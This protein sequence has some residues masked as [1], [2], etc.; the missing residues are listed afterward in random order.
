MVWPLP[1]KMALYQVFLPEES[2]PMG[3]QPEPLL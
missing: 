1:S 2:S 3:S